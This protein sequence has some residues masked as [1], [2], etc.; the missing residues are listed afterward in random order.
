MENTTPFAEWRVDKKGPWTLNLPS[1]H[2][3][4]PIRDTTELVHSAQSHP[5]VGALD[6]TKV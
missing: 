2:V 6:Q 1:R 3:R 5:E 4:I